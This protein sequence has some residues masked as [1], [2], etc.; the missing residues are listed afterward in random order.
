MILLALGALLALFS[1]AIPASAQT[2]PSISAP[3]AYNMQPG[4]VSIGIA[5]GIFNSSSGGLLDFAV[6][7]Q[8]SSSGS[9]QVEI[10]HGASNGTFCTN[11]SN[12]N[13]NP[14]LIP[15][16]SGVKGNAIATGQFR[17]S[18]P[19]D[20]AVATN[21]GIVFLENNDAGTFSISASAITS[22]N[23][24]VALT[25]GLFNG[26]TTPDIAAVAP[27]VNGS[28]S[29]SVYFGNGDGTFNLSASYPVSSPWTGCSEIVSG[30][31][32]NQTTGS[33]L[34]LICRTLSTAVVLV[35]LNPGSSKSY[36][37]FYYSTPYSDSIGAGV[38]PTF[39][40]GTLNGQA[41]IFISSVLNSLL[42]YQGNG[43][44][45][46]TNVLAA[47]YGLGP[48]GPLS[49][50][51]DTSTA[52]DFASGAGV[53]TFTA[54]SQ[55]GTL[56]IGTWNSTGRMGPAGQTIAAGSSNLTQ[57][58]TY[59]VIDAGVA[60]GSYSDPNV[61]GYPNFVPYV[62]ERSVSV[63]LVTLN[64][65]GTVKSTNAAPIY[66]GSGGSGFSAPPT[67]ATGD[68]NGD[69]VIDLAV[70][71]AD[72]STG[73]A[74]ITVYLA[75]S[76]GSLP[77]TTSLPVLTANNT[78]YSGTDAVVA[79]KFRPVQNGKTLYDLAVFSFGEIA[80]FT[81]KGDG[82]FNTGSTYFLSGDANYPGFYFNPGSGHSFAP[83]LTATDVNGDGL[84]DLVLTLPEDNCAASG[85]PS[86]GAVYILISNGDG[87]FQ[88]PVFVPPPVENPISVAAAKFFGSSLPD[89]VF[90]NGGEIC[91]GNSATTK[92]NAVAV[93]QNKVTPGATTISAANF[94]PGVILTSTQS[95]DPGVPNVTSVAS[96]DFNGDGS[97]DLVVSN[98]NGIQILL[99]SGTGTFSPTAQ[100]VLPL[101][102]GDAIPGL[103]CNNLDNYA[104]CITNDAQVTTGSFFT[105]G[106][107]DVAAA[108]SGVV[109]V[110]Q[111]N[112]G[113][114]TPPV[115]GF[116]AGTDSRAISGTLTGPK[117][118]NNLL[119]ATSNG[120]A[121]LSNSGSVGGPAIATFI[122][123]A[124]ATSI[125][126]GTVEIGQ[127]SPEKIL[128]LFNGGTGPL[129]LYLISLIDTSSK[130]IQ[131]APF[132]LNSI[133]CNASPGA[134]VSVQVPVS[135]VPNLTLQ[136]GIACDFLLTMQ[137]TAQGTYTGTFNFLDNA[138]QTN[139]PIQVPNGQNF[140]QTIQ[141][142]GTAP[143]GQPYATFTSNG[144]SVPSDAS[145][146]QAV[147]INTTQSIQ[148][149]VTNT[150]NGLLTLDL[151]YFNLLPPSTANGFSYTSVLCGGT[152]ANFP[153]N[154]LPSQSCTVNV[155]F[156]AT[157]GG[158]FS[159]NL[160][161]LD[162]A[163]AGESNISSAGT[164]PNFVQA[165]SLSATVTT[166]TADVSII[167][168]PGPSETPTTG[169]PYVFTL[170]M[171]N[172]GPNVATNPAI[173]FTFSS[174]VLFGSLSIQG[175]FT[176]NCVL[177]AVGSSVTSF[178]CKYSAAALA[179]GYPA[180][181]A[182]TVTPTTSGS[183]TLTSTI[184]A[185]QIDPNSSN[186]TI[187]SSVSFTAPIPPAKPGP[188]SSVF[189]SPTLGSPVPTGN[190]PSAIAVA[191]FNKD[192]NTDFAVVNTKDNTVS[193]YLGSSIG[194]FTQASGSPY[195]TTPFGIAN[196]ETP[197][198]IAV[199]DFNGDGNLDIAV[200][201]IP[202]GFFSAFGNLFTGHIG[203]GV[204]I[205]LGNGD[206]TFRGGGPFNNP[207]NF[208][209]GG[210]LPT[211]IAVADLN[212]DGH[213]D[214]AI[215]NLN[216]NNISIML[217][218]GQGNFGSP[219]LIPVGSHPAAITAFL[220]GTGLPILAFANAEDGTVGI[221]LN[222]GGASFRPAVGSPINVGIRP[223]SI[224][225]GDVNG[226]GKADLVVANYS[227]SSVSVLLGNGNGTFAAAKNF[228]AGVHPMSVAVADLN[229][230]GLPDVLV[231]NNTGNQVSL[232]AGHGDGTFA[233]SKNFSVLQAPAAIALGNFGGALGFAA[234]STTLDSVGVYSGNVS[235]IPVAMGL[236]ISKN[237]GWSFP[238]RSTVASETL[239]ITNEGGTSYPGPV[240]LVVSNLSSN[241]SL[242]NPT[243]FTRCSVAA[244]SPYIAVPG[245]LLSGASF[246]VTVQVSDPS[247]TAISFTPVYLAP[248]PAPFIP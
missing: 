110:F 26:D 52:V 72:N 155:Q 119:V 38:P 215:T 200:T 44:G 183:F 92:A 141:L 233:A 162:N 1:A 217:G 60:G 152:A 159:T 53:S 65:D 173:T 243:G 198:A 188:V 236:T 84:D 157:A 190:A 59:V 7:E 2:A 209:T 31:F 108:V 19:T 193:I 102:A 49:I 33:D 58:T 218:D 77:S 247:R 41:T 17:S 232:L 158:T 112:A 127:S 134:P 115:Q 11:C 116:V 214:L 238:P 222:L 29:F 91:S 23:G 43:S 73:D 210:D 245:A 130:T 55:S 208:G 124:Y 187:H 203:G 145:I 240:Y 93:L 230:D 76:D 100:G 126:F 13:P 85:S 180:I 161:F 107:T 212:G 167:G 122:P 12:A 136:P 63:Y 40:V 18:G 133:F 80:I 186:N 42:G 235:C 20:I 227:S 105:G 14:D 206:G 176:P 228:A 125:D 164:A 129:Q 169:S 241:A 106:E 81:S 175:G 182:L 96:G 185:D 234:L 174:P 35:Y 207:N 192:G 154:L 114:L 121:N 5:T 54:Y 213:P 135:S 94:T 8:I 27:G 39:A 62:D 34:A 9:Y 10:F 131:S 56:P 219:T 191:D 57:G 229:Y 150:G 87:T 137:P 82:T 46:F 123:Y 163:G 22:T 98:T 50:L 24:F 30:N 226:D 246:T 149:A 148:L 64:T 51:S 45:V 3:A 71:G 177:P 28:V 196:G 95:T 74:E 171:L 143:P 144:I 239:T 37:Y 248:G 142:T 216:S 66:S 211:G 138:A 4:T 70:G 172:N 165:Y 189:F 78:N 202:T 90:A 147:P 140:A 15:L 117:G 67:F 86:Q 244:S 168:E 16:G 36:S 181:T 205:L 156:T 153:V 199:G 61:T 128:E 170:G 47:P 195:S 97:P 160:Y 99:N 224:A 132:V 237:S 139:A 32:Q 201:T 184:S 179:P 79:G 69:G 225:S 120:V 21:T 220:S 6:L 197:I 118:L 75:N 146:L 88:N 109:Y 178:T 194:T 104:G 25:V 223:V 111:N 242:N 221:L 151:V 48:Q 231:A 166:P 103:L 113:T 89:L 68:F 101:Y 204:S 83:V